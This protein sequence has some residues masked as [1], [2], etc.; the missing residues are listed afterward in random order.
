[1]IQAASTSIQ[2]GISRRLPDP[3]YI[4]YADDILVFSTT[5]NQAV[6][7]LICVLYAFSNVSGIQLNLN[8]TALVPF[9]LHPQQCSLLQSLLGCPATT[10]P[11]KYLGLPLTDRRPDRACFQSLI[12]KVASK[13]A[14]WKYRLLSRAGRVVLASSVLSSIPIYLMSVFSLPAWVIKNLDKVRRNF[15]WKG[16]HSSSKAIHLVS[17]DKMCLSKAYGGFGL[18]NLKLQ[19]IS[20]L[21]RWIWWLYKQPASLWTYIAKQLYAKRDHNIPPLAWN[22]QGSFFWNDIFNLRLYFQL[23]TKSAV[24]SGSNTLLWYDNW[25]GNIFAFYGFENSMI[26]CKNI[27]LKR[28]KSRLYSLF[29]SALTAVQA[30]KL[31]LV[32]LL[33]N[34]STPDTLFWR[35]RTDATYSASSLYKRLISVGK[36][37][38]HF[39]KLW[40]LKVPPSIRQFLVF[41]AHGRIM[42]QDQLQKRHINFAPQC[43]L[44]GEQ[45][46]ETQFHLFCDCT[47]AKAI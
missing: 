36:I 35:W 23:S 19:N 26:P 47:F 4:Q 16:P 10:L 32:S 37:S 27:T 17:W 40:K 11:I 2:A 43:N 3:Y 44:C 7:T 8:K 46:L 13:L 39:L 25:G 20:L 34:S 30:E 38:F 31:A 14:G 6:R 5:K 28:A 33:P 9:N 21:I 22:A 15:I 41:L 42:T 1:M 45:I 18:I 29:A 24:T 12:D